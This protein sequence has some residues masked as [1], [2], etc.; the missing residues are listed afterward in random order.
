MQHIGIIC[1]FNPFHQGHA[2]RLEQVRRAFP[3]KGIVCLM[4]GNFVQRGEFSL[5][6]KYSRAECALLGGADLVLE[7]PF[8]FSVLSAE[9]FGKSGVSLLSRLGVLDTLAF[10]TEISEKER[11]VSCA[12]HLSSE[13]F[14]A[15]LSA[16]LS[17][18][19]GI[20]YPAARERVYE[21]IFGKEEILSYPNA[22]LAVEYCRANLALSSPL[23]PFPV[24]RQGAGVRD[25][26]VKSTFSSATAIRLAIRRGEKAWSVPDTTLALMKREEREGRFPVFMDTMLPILRYL[27]KTRPEK[28]LKE[29]Y[30]LSA[31]LHRAKRFVGEV[32]SLEELVEKMGCASF[33]DSRIRRALLSLLCDLP[34]HV[35]REEPA[36]TLVL[37]A[38]EKGREILGQ[39]RKAS[40][41]PIFT[42][43]THPL[44]SSD[45][46]ILRQ[47]SR[48]HRAEEIY[49][50]A[51]PSLQEEGYFLKRHPI[52]L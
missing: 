19:K 26:G 22:S 36:Y 29:I 23:A 45:H 38:N 13:A 42:K 52:F 30:A 4:S 27:L 6:E 43:P 34:R 44:R 31:I 50:M 32:S 11:L 12:E 5:M 7:L 15:A 35:E 39:M 16:Y 14:S 1:E 21:V 51:F 40:T 37:G 8:P 41:V 47:A 48:A 10:G 46:T 24:L 18:H 28:E 20:G 25:E 49:A 3:E 33:T 2:Y 9:G 17:E